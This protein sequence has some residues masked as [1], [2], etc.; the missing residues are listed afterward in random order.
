MFKL[1]V[2]SAKSEKFP[3]VVPF[4]QNKVILSPLSIRRKVS[5]IGQQNMHTNSNNTTIFTLPSSSTNSSEKPPLPNINRSSN[6]KQNFYLNKIV[7]IK[8]SPLAYASLNSHTHKTI[9]TP[10]KKNPKHSQ[11]TKTDFVES[12]NFSDQSYYDCNCILCATKIL[13]KNRQAL[14]PFA[15]LNDNWSLDTKKFFNYLD[16]I[17]PTI[18]IEPPLPAATNFSMFFTTF[19]QIFK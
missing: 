7:S 13:K 9:S 1:R 14:S 15:K 12:S 5:Q 6:S 11:N 16:N 19:I 4:K 10:T 2:N 8:G 17:K 18:K 3:Q